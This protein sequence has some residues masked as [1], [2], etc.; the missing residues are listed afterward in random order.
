MLE[1]RERRK[2]ALIIVPFIFAWL[3]SCGTSFVVLFLHFTLLALL[4][5]Q[6]ISSLYS[7]LRRVTTSAN[8]QTLI[9]A[10]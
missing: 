5:A 9:S 3:H 1:Y 6:P 2:P 7:G 10:I 4:V 8:R